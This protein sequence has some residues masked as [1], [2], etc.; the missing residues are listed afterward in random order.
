[1]AS[2]GDALRARERWLTMRRALLPLLLSIV[3]SPSA[4]AVSAEPPVL[5]PDVFPSVPEVRAVAGV[6]RLELAVVIDPVTGEPTFAYGGGTGAGPTI[7]VDPGDTIDL[8]VRNEARPANGRSNEVNIHFHGL[9]VSPSAPGDDT[10][11]TLARYGEV[12]HYR[13]HVP[14]NHEP[15]LYWYHPHVHGESYADVTDG[16]SGAIVVEGLQQHL[17]ALARMRERIIVLRDVPSGN[18]AVDAD[19]P[20]TR[21]SGAGSAAQ[22][23]GGKPCRA[24]SG[25]M[26]TLNGQPRAQIG[27][28]PGERQ[29]FR[30][31]NASGGRY[32]DLFV[33]GAI[34]TL[35]AR[36][37]IPLDAFPGNAPGRRVRH[38][39]L[40]PAARA[41][42]VVQA[43]AHR[44]VLRSACVNTG[45]AGDADPA[46]I[47][48]DLVDPA[49]IF[50]PAGAKPAHPGHVLM[51]SPALRVG[52]ALPRNWYSRP[53]PAPAAY[54]T[55]RFTEDER[56]FYIN[57]KAFTMA[58]MDGPP[59]IVA[60]SGTV[61]R[62]TIVNDTDE[63]HD[64]HIHQV[65]F[66]A[67][68]IDGV[69][70]RAP[71]WADT[72]NVPPRRHVRGLTVPGSVVLAI[73]F[74]DPVVR[75]TFVYH[76]HILDHGDQGMMA[77]IRVQ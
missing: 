24:E 2:T 40:P 15:G 53:L 11:G 68:S 4:V 67:E 33:D 19:M 59:A 62:W 44:T 43:P 6:A 26:T 50:G 66:V 51:R 65:H 21:A 3:L 49:T 57:G 63:V 71:V 55:I 18:G 72:V 10:L 36:D 60:R 28:H 13:V 74:R 41:E 38:L 77:L 56:G 9:T 17:P 27:I 29:F 39:L 32:F 25:L 14:R 45:S 12:L 16:I 75:G 70:V 30:V 48:A 37:G 76:C 73:D 61:E 23:R 46:I 42:F 34:L 31:V 20:M 54:R 64:F 1:M 47:L 8:T 22:A 7:R 58:D 5:L 52:A 35:V 69:A